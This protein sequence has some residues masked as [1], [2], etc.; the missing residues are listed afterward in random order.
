MDPP[1][2]S[3]G[4]SWTQLRFLCSSRSLWL[5]HPPIEQAAT[6]DRLTGDL[7]AQVRLAQHASCVAS[8][9]EYIDLDAKLVAGNHWPAKL[10]AFDTC[11]QQQLVLA[12]GKLD[13][14]QHATCLC[15]RIHH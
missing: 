14:Q 10:G 5:R 15:H 13:E 9:D 2:P 8:P 11:E 1:R 4:Y 3:D 6:D 12:V 7:V